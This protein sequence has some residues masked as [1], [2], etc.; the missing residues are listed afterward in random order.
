MTDWFAAFRKQ[1]DCAVTVW[2]DGIPVP[3]WQVHQD[4]GRPC[5]HREQQ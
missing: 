3:C 2:I 1:P 5:P 4:T